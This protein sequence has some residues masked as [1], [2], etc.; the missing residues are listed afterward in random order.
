[1]TM[2]TTLWHT[3]TAPLGRAM[4]CP[5]CGQA[6]PRT[7]GPYRGCLECGKVWIL[8]T[9][10][11]HRLTRPV[12]ACHLWTWLTQDPPAMTCPQCG[13]PV[14][15]AVDPRGYHLWGMHECP[16]CGSVQERCEHMG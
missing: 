2:F 1:M 4:P 9:H 11:W 13:T 7:L 3:L 14:P 6:L 16:G 15:H 12:F 8:P 10:R 5:Q